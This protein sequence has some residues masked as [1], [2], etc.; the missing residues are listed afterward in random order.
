MFPISPAIYGAV[1]TQFRFHVR[2]GKRA[3]CF[4]EKFSPPEFRRLYKRGEISRTA[5]AQF[6]SRVRDARLAFFTNN[7]KEIRFSF[8]IFAKKLLGEM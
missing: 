1:N 6:E 4:D 8:K 3:A 7:F 5:M 2:R